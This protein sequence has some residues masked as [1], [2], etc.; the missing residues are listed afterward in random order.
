MRKFL[1]ST[2]A[3]AALVLAPGPA[4][5][6]T[7]VVVEPEVDTW[8]MEQP[9]DTVV[10]YDGDVVVGTALP[11]T[12]ELVEVPQHTKYRYVVLNKRRVLVDGESRKVIKVYE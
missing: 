2:A 12:V 5:A 3:V 11:D 7:T 9:G 10:T 1:I 8:V 6:D 4:F